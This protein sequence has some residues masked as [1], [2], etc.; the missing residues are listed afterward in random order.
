[1]NN[2][3]LGGG[4]LLGIGVLL[5][6][7][8]FLPAWVKRHQFAAAQKN[9]VRIQRTLR[10]LA[11]TSEVPNEVRVE[12]TAREALAHERILEA[13]GRTQLAE[14]EA[15][16]AEA[17]AAERAALLEAKASKR[18][19]E[20]LRRELWMQTRG[21]RLARLAAAG[22]SLVALLGVISGIVLAV[23]GLGSVLLGVSAAALVLGFG[24]LRAMA[25]KRRARETLHAQQSQ[26]AHRSVDL[27]S[28]TARSHVN[29][30]RS[31]RAHTRDSA[32]TQPR[33]SSSER[34]SQRAV[35]QSAEEVARAKRILELAREQA[36]LVQ[37]QQ[38]AVNQNQQAG[39]A[40]HARIAQS[41]PNRPGQPR[42]APVAREQ[43]PAVNETALKSMGIIGD[44]AEGMPDVTAALLRRRAA[45]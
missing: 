21:M 12:A 26:T 1:M 42:Q 2:S 18:K 10:V 5:W 24:L 35:A 29:A 16:L 39:G 6:A 27:A 8:Y 31:N 41:S 11:E 19:A 22:V 28:R 45:S 30:S 32:S 7:V 34:V 37:R 43:Q 9:A 14:H 40:S 20:A 36:E 23:L 15:K 13:A 17:K 38:I 4:V 33:V 44:T 3:V 25:P